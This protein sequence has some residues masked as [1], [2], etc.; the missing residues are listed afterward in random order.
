MNFYFGELTWEEKEPPPEEWSRIHSPTS[1]LVYLLAA[2]AGLA[3]IL[4]LFGWLV[5]VSIFTDQSGIGQGG[6]GGS[7]PWAAVALALLLFIPIHEFV[8]ALWLPQYG[9]S[10]Q[11]IMIIWPRKLRF[12]V[13]YEGCLTRGR[14]L[15]MRLAPFVWIT[16]ITIGLLTLF[17]VI[18]GPYFL[19]VFLQLLFL[20]NG[21]GSGGDVIAVVWVL[22]QVPTGTEICFRRGKAYWWLTS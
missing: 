9:L 16:L 4:L 5:A 8:H 17:Q 11:T 10:P 6:G 21:I 13:Y 12:G 7:T 22:F 1:R 20:L 2:V 18:P 15:M 14:W 3:L 19:V